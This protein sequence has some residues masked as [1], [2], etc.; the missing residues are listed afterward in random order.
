MARGICNPATNKTVIGPIDSGVLNNGKPARP[1]HK[2]TLQGTL[3]LASRSEVKRGEWKKFR[4]G[5]L[6]IHP[7]G[8]VAYKPG[9]V[10]A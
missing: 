2:T 5:N 6:Q 1:S 7:I 9:L 8:S 3:I 10:S 4:G